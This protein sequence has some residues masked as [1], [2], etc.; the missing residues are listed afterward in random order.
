VPIIIALYLI[1]VDGL[2]LALIFI[3]VSFTDYLD[4]FLARRLKQTSKLGAFLD[5]VADKFIVTVVLILI[6]SN[7]SIQ[8]TA[9]NPNVLVIVVILI[10]SREIAVSALREWMAEIGQR[11]KVA[12]GKIGK[13]KTGSQMLAITLL[14]YAKDIGWFPTLMVGEIFLYIAGLLTFHSMLVYLKA[15]GSN[16]DTFNS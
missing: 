10:I 4:G 14:L 2:W 8:N 11:S 9:I 7:Q 15:A 12:V 3:V 6:I 16:F 13:L 5:P 1:E